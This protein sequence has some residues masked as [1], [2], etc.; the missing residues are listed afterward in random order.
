L[1]ERLHRWKLYE[2]GCSVVFW[3]GHRFEPMETIPLAELDGETVLQGRGWGDA[4]AL[5]GPAGASIRLPHSGGNLDHV[6]HLTAA[7][8]GI[9]LLPRRWPVL[10]PLL[11]RPLADETLARLVVL[12]V[13][14]GRQHSPALD[15][16]VKL[17]RVRSFALA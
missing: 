2:E 3:P 15:G 6:Q 9:A 5:C 17:I 16:F 10:P 12:A 14:S 8:L 13:V 1:P 7:R 11:S 4:A